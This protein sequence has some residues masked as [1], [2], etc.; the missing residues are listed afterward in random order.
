[1][2]T[3]FTHE[4][5]VVLDPSTAPYLFFESITCQDALMPVGLSSN[6]AMKQG[7]SKHSKGKNRWS[8]T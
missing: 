6:H 4:R 2:A 5:P 7:N 1:M 3:Y 8:Q